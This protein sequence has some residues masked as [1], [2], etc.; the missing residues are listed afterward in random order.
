MI[1]KGGAGLTSAIHHTFQ[2]CWKQGE[3]PKCWKKENRIYLPKQDKPDCCIPKTYRGISLSSVVGKVYE[4][5]SDR[6][7]RAW[8]TTEG[9]W[10]PFQ[11]AYR[12]D[13]SITQALLYYTLSIIQ[14]FNEGKHTL[15]CFIDLEG[16]FDTV[17]RA[18]II[19]KLHQAGLT[20]R[21]L[22][23]IDS[24]L[25]DRLVCNQVKWLHIGLVLHSPWCSTR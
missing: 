14:G 23:F 8:M 17:W 18:S 20:E 2:S 21:L 6:R 3:V 5:I 11:F 15:A 10:D 7:L 24:Y 19:Y 9:L 12:K 25:C 16:A 1:K 22:C 4:R 13:H